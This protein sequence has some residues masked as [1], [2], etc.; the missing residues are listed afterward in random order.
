V[1]EG[2]FTDAE[3][4]AAVEA[5][6]DPERF[7]AATGLIERA[8]PQLQKLLALALR[9]GGWFDDTHEHAIQVAAMTDDPHERVAAVKTLMG[10]EAR[11]GMMVG[12]A[13][14]YEL[15]RELEID[16]N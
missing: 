10:E 6:S 16:H 1:P 13:V 3:L 14:G 12:V 11:L 5:L 9:E 15:A 2:A 8:A 4:D 7:A